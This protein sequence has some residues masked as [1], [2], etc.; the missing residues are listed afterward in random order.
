MDI[1][2]FGSYHIWL[3]TCLTLSHLLRRK[4]YVHLC[5]YLSPRMSAPLLSQNAIHVL[6]IALRTVINFIPDHGR[7]TFIVQYLWCNK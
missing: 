1:Q 5:T 3:R 6:F 4:V 7:S 2:S